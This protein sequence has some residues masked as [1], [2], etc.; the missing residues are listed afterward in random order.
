ME[1]CFE[2]GVYI[3]VLSEY[4]GYRLGVEIIQLERASSENTLKMIPLY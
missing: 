1:I 4:I 2:S 3:E